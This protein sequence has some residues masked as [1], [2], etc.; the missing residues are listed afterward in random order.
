MPEFATHHFVPGA[1][2]ARDV[3]PAHIGPARRLGLQNQ[4]DAIVDAVNFRLCLNLGKGIT[5]V[6][7]I[8]AERLGGLDHLIGVVGLT[9]PDRHQGLELIVLAE[10]V[11]LKF[12]TRHDKTLTLGYVDGDT[13]FL[14]VGRNHHL[15]R[16][17]AELQITARQVIGAQGLDIGI[18]LG[19]RVLVRLGVPAQPAA[20][21]EI[22][23]VAQGRFTEHLVANNA[24]FL[25]L[26]PITL[27]DR[28]RKVDPVALHRRHR[29]NDFSRVQAAI[30]VLAFEFLFGPVQQGTVKRP[31][32]SQSDFAQGLAQGIFVE[33]LVAAEPDVGDGGPLLDD[34]HQHIAIDFDPDILEQPQREQ[35]LDRGG[36]LFVIVRVANPDRQGRENRP[37]LDPLQALDANVAYRKRIDRPCRTGEPSGRDDERKKTAAKSIELH[38]LIETVSPA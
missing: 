38:F 3:D 6:P 17:D 31:T 8:I 29:G 9:G 26:G 2:V 14:L 24:D 36:S 32:V 25:Y 20:G 13:D 7:E 37:G 30:D 15:G 21:I 34:H 19:A 35:R 23:Q 5:E 33:L 16:F 28:E 27:G 11:A 22:E 4:R 1:V 18:E 12:Y 10:I